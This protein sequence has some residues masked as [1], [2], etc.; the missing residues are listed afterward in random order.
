MFISSLWN[1]LVIFLCRLIGIRSKIMHLMPRSGALAASICDLKFCLSML[2]QHVMMFVVQ[3]GLSVK[4]WM[5]NDFLLT[6]QYHIN[7]D[8]TITKKVTFLFVMAFLQLA[9]PFVLQVSL[10]PYLYFTVCFSGQIVVQKNSPRGP[11]FRRAGPGKRVSCFEI[12]SRNC[13][14]AVPN[15]D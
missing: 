9:I 15:L 4:C 5:T 13:C 1:G 8:D 2:S 10:L 7:E 3:H 6:R 11:H 14:I 12:C